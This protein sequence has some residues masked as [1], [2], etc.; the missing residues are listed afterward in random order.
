[1][2]K[3]SKRKIILAIYTPVYLPKLNKIQTE[4]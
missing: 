4:V 1:M 2:A 3:M